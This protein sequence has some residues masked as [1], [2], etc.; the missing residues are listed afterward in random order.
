MSAGAAQK[1][2]NTRA[3]VV[4]CAGSGRRFGGDKMLYPLFSR[5]LFTYALDAFCGGC[6]CVV[7]VASKQNKVQIEDY[8]TRNAPTGVQ[9]VVVL[10][11]ETRGGSACAGLAAVP[12]GFETVAV[13]DGARPFTSRRLIEDCFASAERFGSGVAAA[14]VTDT[15]CTKSGEYLPRG[16]LLAL[17]TPQAF[18]LEKIRAAYAA[19][20]SAGRDFTDDSAVFASAFGAVRYVTGDA[21]NIKITRESD[22]SGFS[23]GYGYDIHKFADG[24][25][26]FLCGE[27]F[28]GERGL[29][30]HSDADAPLHAL[31]DALLASCALPD[32]G[33]HFPPGAPEFKGI[34]S[35]ELLRRVQKMAEEQGVFALSASVAIVAERPKI[36]SKID[37][38]RQ[39]I[40][41]VLKISPA[42][43]SVTATT[44]EGVGEI[45]SG[46]ALAARAFVLARKK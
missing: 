11:G 38:M 32:I 13:A 24:R 1:P 12:A 3:A 42:Q 36:A 46:S 30:G 16:E 19:A 6:G 29:D 7:A 34:S 14:E 45:G 40:A 33:H 17:Q 10:G 37:K 2:N 31:C 41:A 23:C 15:I 44:A 8:L 21:D 35:Q 43:V 22:I 25:K 4:L 5:P 20:A 39:N 28:A 27:E 9:T 26:L 18:S